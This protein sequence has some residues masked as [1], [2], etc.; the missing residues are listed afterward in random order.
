MRTAASLIIAAG[1]AHAACVLVPSDRL[2]ARD[3]VTA[4][5]LFQSLDPDEALGFAPFPGTVRILTSHDVL[6]IARRYGLAFAPGEAAPSICVERIVHPLSVDEVSAA[7]LSSL[8]IP[9]VKLEVLEFSNQPVPSGR[10]EFLR[11]A[12]NKP[13][14]NNTQSSV[15]WQGK[16]LYDDHHSLAVWARV[17]MSVEREMVIAKE[18]IPKGTV[19]RAEQITTAR[20]AQF[21]LHEPSQHMSFVVAGK[22][23][24]RTLLPGQAIVAEML[25][26][27]KDVAG[28]ETVHVQAID[29]AASIRFDAV[30]QSS[31]RKGDVII[32]HNPSSGKNFRA[33]IDGPNQVIVRE[34]L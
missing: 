16:L 3:L 26:E 32:V 10:L 6:L 24:R 18:S 25:D 21:P 11:S 7:L 19:I 34:V 28:G 30:A 4:V 9:D 2:L 27:P 15:V 22:V 29:G 17:R 5:P 20:I 33:L 8:D 23:A 31:G 14:V 12:L 13:P 1:V